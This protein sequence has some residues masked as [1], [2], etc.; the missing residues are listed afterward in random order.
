MSTT[1]VKLVKKTEIAQ[2]TLE[3]QLKP[4]TGYQYQAGQYADVWISKPPAVYNPDLVRTLSFS[5]APTDLYITFAFR[6]SRSPFKSFISSA[7]IGTR[8]YLSH[9]LGYFGRD[10]NQYQTTLWI[11]GGIGI[12]PFHS[13]LNMRNKSA[14]YCITI[15]SF[16]RTVSCTPYQDHFRSINDR[17]FSY[18]FFTTEHRTMHDRHQL[19]LNSIKTC[20]ENLKPSVVYLCGSQG[21]ADTVQDTLLYLGFP[22]DNIRIENFG[23]IQI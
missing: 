14:D 9:A 8:L 22:S 21:F 2:N 13:L 17:N 12:T 4:E 1:S 16:D 5:S 15:L 23:S 7:P 19:F 18:S 20:L 10:I 3:I 11:A 6:V